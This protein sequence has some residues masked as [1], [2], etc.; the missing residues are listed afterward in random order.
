MVECVKFS[1]PLIGIKAVKAPFGGS[2]CHRFTGGY[3]FCK[4]LNRL[5]KSI[6]LTGNFGM[7]INLNIIFK[8]T[9]VFKW[10]KRGFLFEISNEMSIAVKTDLKCNV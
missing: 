7:D 4:R 1:V 2:I 5:G 6:G 9:S 8:I 3:D 10:G